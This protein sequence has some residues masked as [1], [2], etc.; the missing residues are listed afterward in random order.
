VF[1]LGDRH[2]DPAAAR[3]QLEELASIVTV[4]AL[5]FRRDA[6]ADLQDGRL[7]LLIP[8]LAEPAAA[9]G[10]LAAAVSAVRSHLDP[11]ARAVLGTLAGEVS[12]APDSRRAAEFALTVPST[13]PVLSF[14][15]VRARLVTDSIQNHLETQLISHPELLDPRIVALVRDEPVNARTLL[16]YLDAGC[17]VVRVAD[18]LGV[19]PTTVRHRLRRAQNRLHGQLSEPDERLATHLQLRCSLRARPKER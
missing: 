12:G 15:D 1:V 14:D 11:Q 7:Y 19:H 4:H 3:L 13:E 9:L 10:M 17:D 8:N 16:D 2:R 5:A 6:L 18:L